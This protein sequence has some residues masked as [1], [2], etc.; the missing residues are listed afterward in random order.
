VGQYEKIVG[1]ASA[2]STRTTQNRVI[3]DIESPLAT[4]RGKR[5]YAS[6]STY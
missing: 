2:R 1:K 4:R 3:V 6:T 5:E